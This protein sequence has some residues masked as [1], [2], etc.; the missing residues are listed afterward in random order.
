MMPVQT[1]DLWGLA[2][3]G[4][5]E[6][7]PV[8]LAAAVEDQ[9][10]ED[11]LDYRTRLL[12]RDSVDAL[13][14]HWGVG[15]VAEWLSGSP[16]GEKIKAITRE[17]F[18]EPGFSSLR[19]RLMEKTDP[20][21]VKQYLRSVGV[22]LVRPTPVA[23]GGAIALILAGYLSRR[24]EDIDV[25][26]EV[27]AEIRSQHQLLAQLKKSY[28]LEMAHFQQHYLPSRW[29]ERLHSIE[30][31]GQLRVSLVDVYDVFLSKLTSIRTKD[32][33]DLR[34]V[35]PQLDKETLVRRLRETMTSALA[36][37]EQR[38]RAERNWYVLYGEALPT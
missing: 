36:E 21:T 2:L 4:W 11:G 16:V 26:D 37:A 22:T 13:R 7:D 30:S 15:R 18:D 5:P 28:G 17:T 25:V 38:R 33:D 23:I 10:G 31:F 19:D 34:V 9:A 27:P 32:C 6:I 12:I 3:S 20:E 14:H 29:S 35:L 24:T 8:D 1:R